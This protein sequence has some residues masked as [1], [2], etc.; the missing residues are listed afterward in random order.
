MQILL[1]NAFG[2]K[3]TTISLKQ[4]RLFIRNTSFVYFILFLL[5]INAFCDVQEQNGKLISG[6]LTL[7]TE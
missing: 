3:Y 7:F 4:I 1:G 2:S 6:K 5:C